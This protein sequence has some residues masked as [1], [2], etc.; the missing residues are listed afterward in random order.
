MSLNGMSETTIKIVA[1][2]DELR[3]VCRFR[4]NVYV[5]EM[6]RWP[7]HARVAPDPTLPPYAVLDVPHPVT[8]QC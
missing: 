3:D 8:M 2:D 7:I 6:G 1:A 5:N 4:Y